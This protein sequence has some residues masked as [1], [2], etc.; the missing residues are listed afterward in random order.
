MRST[1]KIDV[2]GMSAHPSIGLGVVLTRSGGELVGSAGLSTDSPI[3][4]GGGGPV[5][6]TGP[7]DS[8]I[9]VGTISTFTQLTFALIGRT[10]DLIDEGP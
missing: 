7:T 1:E 2:I 10:H 6:Q 9:L 5:A 4:V 3:R 8:P